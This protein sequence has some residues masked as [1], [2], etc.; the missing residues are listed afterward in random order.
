MLNLHNIYCK[1][2][3]TPE[4]LIFLKDILNLDIYVVTLI[5]NRF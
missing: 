5:F 1:F 4:A 3:Y 2:D